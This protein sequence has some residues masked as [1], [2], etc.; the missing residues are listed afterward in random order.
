MGMK[1]FLNKK[2]LVFRQ[3]K[4]EKV[5]PLARHKIGLHNIWGKI[6]IWNKITNDVNM[7][8]DGRSGTSQKSIG[9]WFSTSVETNHH[10][11]FYDSVSIKLSI[12]THFSSASL[13]YLNV[14]EMV[15]SETTSSFK[16]YKMIHTLSKSWLES[17]G[18]QTQHP[19]CTELSWTK[20]KGEDFFF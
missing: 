5:G 18:R 9:F 10:S 2:R 4:G 13:K 6:K 17:Q 20:W 3:E 19:T 7:R 11:N 14:S 12:L 16:A 15:T 8:A 1:Q